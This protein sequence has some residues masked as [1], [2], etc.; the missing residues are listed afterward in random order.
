MT[1]ACALALEA[2]FGSVV[3]WR[4]EFTAIGRA[5][6][7]GA[8]GGAGGGGAGGVLLIFKPHDGAL[9]NRPAAEH[10][11]TVGG[12]VS[13]LAMDMH[14]DAD[15]S[16]H[17]A[18]A[19]AH[20]D[21]RIDNIDWA[22]VYARYQAA[23]YAASEGYGASQEEAAGAT[24]LDVRRAGVFDQADSIVAGAQWRDPATV[25]QWAADLQPGERVVVY[26]VHGH[27][28]SR[29]VALRLRAAGVDAHF[30]RGGID[31][32]MAAGRPVAPKPDA[33]AAR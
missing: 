2:S 3:R 17:G 22:H 23:V 21:A 11:Q 1:P 7:G 12:G 24:V 28:V 13:I 14:E 25:A 8:G 20:V 15:P 10:A 27:E 5:V 26:C 32:W 9:V 16:D 4:D 31:A 19:A 29:A 33:K 30:L 18:A 6:R